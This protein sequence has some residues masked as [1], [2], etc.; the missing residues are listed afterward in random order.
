MNKFIQNWTYGKHALTVLCSYIAIAT[1]G[2]A[3]ITK[4]VPKDERFCCSIKDCKEI[5]KCCKEMPKKQKVFNAIVAGCCTF[6]M[7]V[8]YLVINHFKKQNK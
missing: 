6:D 4:D 1:V 2:N 5:P 7:S 3:I 8:T